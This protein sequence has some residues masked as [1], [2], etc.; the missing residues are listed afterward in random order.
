MLIARVACPRCGILLQLSQPQ[1]E[2]NLVQ[3][4]KCEAIFPV[5]APV[6]NEEPAPGH[7]L[8]AA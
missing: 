2:G 7:A 5:P 1:Q 3:C 6:R 4:P 8:R